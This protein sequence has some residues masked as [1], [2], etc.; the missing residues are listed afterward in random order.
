MA[1]I[2]AS[3]GFMGPAP[4]VQQRDGEIDSEAVTS[5]G[6][7]SFPSPEV[8]VAALARAAA[9]AEW[10]RRPAG[11]VPSLVDIDPDAARAVVDRWL[12]MEPEGGLLPAS[13][14][15]RLFAAYGVTVWPLVLVNSVSEALAG[16]AE[17]GY[18]VAL[19]ATAEPLRHRPELGTVSL[20][21]AGEDELR[22]AY[23]AMT[24]RL[25]GATAALAVQSM[26]P[27]G[28]PTVVQTADDAFF[29]ALMSFG[30]GGVATDL[31]GDRAFRVLPLT[32]TDVTQLVRSVR[33]APL[34]FGY[35]GS[36]PVDV[37][38]LEQLLLRVARLAH[39]LP[40]VAELELNP[41]I[42]S[43]TG[44]SVLRATAKVAVPSARL[45]T[46]PRRMR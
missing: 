26:A 15:T 17:V 10:R 32:D 41:V 28:V 46:G 45:D 22:A 36:E 11:E 37:P 42:V 1:T 19:K 44:V 23:Q 3:D 7:P 31:L 40:E 24:T 4:D 35:R 14:V 9:Y 16:A 2:L 21:I 8:A 39:E 13:E 25:D 38:A 33:A 29:G 43:R 5:G 34:L 20:D 27:A 18:P 12:L 6:V 30:I